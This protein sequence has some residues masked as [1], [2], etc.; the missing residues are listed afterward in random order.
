VDAE[1]IL[2]ENP[3]CLGALRRLD[4]KDQLEIWTILANLLYDPSVD[5]NYKTELD[6]F[7]YTGSG[8]RQYAD[9]RFILMY[10]ALGDGSVDVTTIIALLP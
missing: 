1:I 4:L 10:S 7:P 8:L 5:D 9:S 2:H 3:L 6:F